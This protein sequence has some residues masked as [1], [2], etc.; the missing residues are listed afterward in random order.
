MKSSGNAAMAN[1][2]SSVSTGIREVHS[3]RNKL[4][5]SKQMKQ[6]Y[7]QACS[8]L[9]LQNLPSEGR[10]TCVHTESDSDSVPL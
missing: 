10:P 4:E 2:S 6:I 5:K 9:S 7:S 8:P 3:H 1:I